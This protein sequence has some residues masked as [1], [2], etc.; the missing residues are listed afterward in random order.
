MLSPEHDCSS[1]A[2]SRLRMLTAAALPL[3][4][5]AVILLQPLAARGQSRTALSSQTAMY[6]RLVRL[7][8]GASNGRILSSVTAF[9]NG[10]NE[11]D[12]YSSTDNGQTFSPLSSI[13]DPQFAGGL[14]CGTLYE[15]PSAVGNLP[16]GTVL[17]AG[18]VGQNT[19]PHQ[20]EIKV[21]QSA[22]GGQ[23]WSYLSNCVNTTNPGGLWEPQFNIASDGALVCHWSDETDDAYSQKLA[24]ARTYD[25]VTWQE[26]SN[27]VASDI[28]ADRPG[29]AV[30]TLLPSGTYFMSYEL[31]GPA[32]CTVFYRTSADGWNWGN[33]T[34]TGTKVAA[35]GGQFF[36]HAPTNAYSANG[37]LLLVGQV[38][39]NSDGSTAS[40][41]G[42]T[43]FTNT[44]ADGS[45]TWQ[46]QAAPVPVPDAQNAVCPNY[47]SPL[48][49]SIDGT[50]VLGLASDASRS[51]CLMYFGTV[52]LQ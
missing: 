38:L 13:T 35:V 14:C 9:P 19:S 27:T 8:H 50:S 51:D 15:L 2:P 3:A 43:I 23:S 30:V 12:I 31:C 26:Q 49:P 29:M 18:S 34:F 17:W 52:A 45:G 10:G 5:L 28:Q 32:A 11:I 46:T 7:E 48:L 36:E 41:N 24:R 22:D 4:L 6:G 21:Y 44:G 25:G 33:P 40:G 47:S 20:M 39:L 1:A 42:E 16:A 37:Q